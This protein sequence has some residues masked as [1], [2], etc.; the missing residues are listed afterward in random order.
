MRFDVYKMP[1]GGAP[2]YLVDVQADLWADLPTRMVIPLL[3]NAGFRG[4]IRDL[5]PVFEIF[6][7]PFV[8]VTQELASI[9]KR[10]LNRPIASLIAQRDEIS[11]ALD[12]LL[13][14]F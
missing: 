9:K 3:A 13:T 11:R 4:A 2:G 10:L 1:P 5:N 7:L 6:E 14:G 12:L 8:L